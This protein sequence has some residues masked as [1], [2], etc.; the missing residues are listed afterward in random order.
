ME[1]DYGLRHERVR[2]RI[3]VARSHK[4]FRKVEDVRIICMSV[5]LYMFM[6]IL[7]WVCIC[8][9]ICEC[10][11]MIR[12]NHSL[13]FSW[14]VPAFKAKVPFQ[15]NNFLSCHWKWLQELILFLCPSLQDSHS[16]LIVILLVRIGSLHIMNKLLSWFAHYFWFAFNN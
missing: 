1:W 7:I 9:G 6:R 5:Y 4:L 2:R 15:K 14:K 12:A 3:Q 8:I 13:I 16:L 10:T 11:Y